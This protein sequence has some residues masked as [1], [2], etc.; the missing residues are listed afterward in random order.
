MTEEVNTTPATNNEDDTQWTNDDFLSFNRPSSDNDDN[1]EEGEAVDDLFAQEEN[2]ITTAN[3]NTNQ[4]LEILPPPPWMMMAASSNGGSHTNNRYYYYVN[5]LVRLHNEI[6]SFCKLMEPQDYELEQREE[7]IT[8][9]RN[10]AQSCFNKEGEDCK[11]M[12]FGSHATG[13]L[14]PTSDIDISIML[15]SSLNNNKTKEDKDTTSEAQKITDQEEMDEWNMENVI[16][17]LNSAFVN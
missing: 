12:V 7:L 14:L 16:L 6:V 10:L 11:V 3:D 4:S 1:E 13:L 5:P 2:D 9:F 17:C 15:S 8:K